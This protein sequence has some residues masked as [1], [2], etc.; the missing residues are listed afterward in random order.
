MTSSC[1]LG[2]FYC[3]F[4]H[5]RKRGKE[6]GVLIEKKNKNKNSKCQSSEDISEQ[7]KRL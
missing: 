2:T 6:V 5:S 7:G 4:G 1:H 3:S